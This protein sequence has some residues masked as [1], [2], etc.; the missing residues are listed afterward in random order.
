MKKIIIHGA[1]ADNAGD[2]HKSG[3]TLTVDDE[4]KAGFIAADR[5]KHLVDIGSATAVAEKAAK[6][7]SAE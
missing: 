7:A 1:A 2:L 6:S 3:A 4:P 5:A